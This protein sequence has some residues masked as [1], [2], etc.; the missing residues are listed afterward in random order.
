MSAK[1][2]I[3]A[4]GSGF[5]VQKKFLCFWLYHRIMDPNTP[6]AAPAPLNVIQV[7]DSAESAMKFI[8]QQGE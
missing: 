6:P 2:R 8:N 1:Y 4:H 3:V 7:F 5:A